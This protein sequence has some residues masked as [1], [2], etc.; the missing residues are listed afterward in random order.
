VS[1]G[2]GEN[3][4]NAPTS[5]PATES[6]QEEEDQVVMDDKPTMKMKP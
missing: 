6:V 3:K 1:V 2:A 5:H 4:G